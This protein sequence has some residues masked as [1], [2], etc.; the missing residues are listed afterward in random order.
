MWPSPLPVSPSL[1]ASIIFLI[2]SSDHKI[3]IIIDQTQVDHSVDPSPA[4]WK[5][6]PS[7]SVGL[8]FLTLSHSSPSD[9]VCLVFVAACMAGT[10]DRPFPHLHRPTF[11]QAERSVI[12]FP[13]FSSSIPL[14]HTVW[15]LVIEVGF[16]WWG[17][18]R[19]VSCLPAPGTWDLHWHFTP[20]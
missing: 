17:S 19:D 4:G 15:F 5:A 20:H 12:F 11:W 2:P 1:Q 14:P 8:P 18:G 3:I 10:P 6:W 7:P 9:L 13:L 16:W